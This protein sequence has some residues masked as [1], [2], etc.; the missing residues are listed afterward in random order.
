MMQNLKRN[1][2][3]SSKLTW[4]IWRI[5]AEALE[6]LKKLYFNGLL[7]TKAYNVWTKKKVQRSYDMKNLA[8]FHQNTFE[9]LKI[10]IL[11]GC[12]Y[13]KYEM[14]EL[15]SYMGFVCHDNEEWCKVWRV[16]DLSF[17][18]WHEEFDKLCP[19]HSKIS[20]ICTFVDY[21]WPKHIWFWPRHIMFELEGC[22]RMC[23]GVMFDGTEY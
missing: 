2:Y 3:V 14:Y 11:M 7:L 5:L 23:R 1:W 15:K 4:G 8:N 16:I 10:G 21:F 17:Q 22:G 20:K 13:P 9:S 19:E 12:F 18:S 6:S